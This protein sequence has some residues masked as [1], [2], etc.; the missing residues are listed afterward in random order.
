[1]PLQSVPSL[2][3]I[4]SPRKKKMIPSESDLSDVQKDHQWESEVSSLLGH[5]VFYFCMVKDHLS[6]PKDLEKMKKGGLSK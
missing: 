6:F 2:L 3:G 1:M 5:E 4:D